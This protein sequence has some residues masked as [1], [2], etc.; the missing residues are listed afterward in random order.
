MK[1]LFKASLV[2]TLVV[3]GFGTSRG[4]AQD[5]SHGVRSGGWQ[6]NALVKAVREAT[7][8]FRD[9]TV[10]EAAGYQLLFGCVS[11]PDAGAMGLHYVNLPLGT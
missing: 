8:R 1:V 10:A 2:G 5:H 4:L 7:E 6:N 9:V 3:M 11:G